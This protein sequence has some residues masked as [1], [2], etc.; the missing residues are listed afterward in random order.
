[1]WFFHSDFFSVGNIP[2]HINHSGVELL[3]LAIGLLMVWAGPYL[4]HSHQ[5]REVSHQL[6]LK[7]SALI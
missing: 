4:L 1:M 3:T 5:L 6:T 7:I 2:Q